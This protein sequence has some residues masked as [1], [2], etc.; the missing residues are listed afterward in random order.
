MTQYP[1]FPVLS[2]FSPLP[3]QQAQI[4]TRLYSTLL[5][6]PT[7]NGS[8]LS[9]PDNTKNKQSK[10]STSTAALIK[11]FGKHV[12]N[13]LTEYISIQ[14]GSSS[15]FSK[16]GIF[17]QNQ[18]IADVAIKREL[19]KG[20]YFVLDLCT[21]FERDMVLVSLDNAGKMFLKGLY[22]DYLKYHKYTGKV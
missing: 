20:L 1:P 15:N 11:P 13:I 14:T 5:Y 8:S 21:E 19:A 2:L 16:G 10:L 6:K 12:W 3:L 18:V 22:N 17:G 4:L 9:F 7:A